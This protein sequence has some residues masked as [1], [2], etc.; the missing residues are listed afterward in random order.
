MALRWGVVVSTD[1]TKR[2]GVRWSNS[3]ISKMVGLKYVMR[4]IIFIYYEH[5]VKMNGIP[6]KQT[7]GIVVVSILGS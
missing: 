2:I 4:I 3:P 7:W 6:Q 5:F 1:T